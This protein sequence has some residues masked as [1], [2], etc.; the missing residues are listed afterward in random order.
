MQEQDIKSLNPIE[1]PHCGRPIIV[2]LIT[3]APELTGVYT[4]EMLQAA[5]QDALARVAA[6]GLPDELTKSTI[7]WINTP[8]VIFGP[9]DVDEIIKNIQKQ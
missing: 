8:D 2:E 9:A 7:D 1:C 6:L 4:P 5:K 3:K